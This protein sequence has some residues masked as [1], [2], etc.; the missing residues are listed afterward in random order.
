[1]AHDKT[2]TLS[3]KTIHLA[4]LDQH[5]RFDSQAVYDDRL[6]EA[7]TAMLR[8]QEA[9]FHE[10]RRAIIVFEGWDAAGKGG[11]IRRLTEKLDPRG[12]KVWPIAAPKPEE[13]GRHYLYRFWQRLPEP[14]TIAVFDRSWYGRVLVE[15]VEGFA[16]KHE[17]KRAYHEINEFEKM[18]T[19]DGVRIVK[20]FLH[21][22]DDEQL[23]R[24]IERLRNP[25]KRW[26]LSGEDLRNRA[27][28]K[29]Y[30]G[31]IDD[32]FAH[33][34]TKHAPW[35]A[36]AGNHKWQARVHVIEG[37][38]KALSEGVKLKPPPLDPQVQAQAA[39]ALGV[40]PAT[41]TGKD[42]GAKAGKKAAKK[43]RKKKKD[44]ADK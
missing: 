15:R 18:L 42:G 8:V 29:D 2:Y 40:S 1:M 14:G 9:Y 26:K 36:I 17:W 33:T 7:Q 38:V 34:S 10:K 39:V 32:M 24:F 31:A 22:T 16:K 19:D 23:K 44:K 11:A 28:R 41:V 21:I 12:C 30:E 20:L 3:G 13:Q 25:Y 37:V 5:K 4:K 27:R 35:H 43:K 6:H